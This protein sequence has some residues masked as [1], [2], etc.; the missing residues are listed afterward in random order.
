MLKIIREILSKSNTAYTFVLSGFFTGLAFSFP[1]ELWYFSFFFL[2]PILFLF[3]GDV[4]NIKQVSYKR[5]LIFG[6]VVGVFS[7]FWFFDIFPLTWLG[8]A[9]EGYKGYLSFAIVWVCFVLAIASSFLPFFYFLRKTISLSSKTYQPL[10]ISLLWVA[11]EYLRAWLLSIIVIGEKS[12]LGAHHSYYSVAYTVSS[13]PY[14]RDLF[15]IGGI[16]LVSFLIIYI[17]CLLYGFITNGFSK[18]IIVHIGIVAF[19]VMSASLYVSVLSNSNQQKTIK[20]SVV[21]TYL[22]PTKT[23]DDDIHKTDIVYQYLL[24]QDK[25][26]ALGEVIITPEN[27]NILRS[28]VKD[29]DVENGAIF[30]NVHVFLGS[31]STSKHHLFYYFDKD[32]KTVSYYEKRLLMPVAEYRVFWT[33]FLKN[34]T[35]VDDPID[36][37]Q[38]TININ[39]NASYVSNT[40]DSQDYSFF[41]SLCSENIS[42]YLY[43]DAV[44]NGADYLVNVASHSLFRGSELLARQTLAINRARAIESGRYFVATFNYSDSYVISD[45]G[46]IVYKSKKTG[47]VE[48]EN[49]LLVQKKQVT[50]FVRFGDYFPVASILFLSCYAIW[51]RDKTYRRGR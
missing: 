1:E 27:I 51:F 37:K 18:N 16:Y 6:I 21:S 29:N 8:Q 38:V 36:T 7:T 49:V 30:T 10:I 24:D 44:I 47:I 5:Q 31:F 34:N 23:T 15:A 25:K 9:G 26:K 20:V 22:P 14:V 41:G 39:K 40:R 3:Y 32:S 45:R 35:Q 11:M 33:S 17:N 42:P 12:L 28:L 2:T 13:V 19:C 46:V 4:G 50:P 43:R 48:H